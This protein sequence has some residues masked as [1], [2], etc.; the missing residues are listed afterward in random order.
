MDLYTRY[1]F[2]FT[3]C[4]PTHETDLLFVFD[5]LALGSVRS[6]AISQFIEK[7]LS[8]INL[9][10]DR[11]RVGREIEN[12]PTGNIPLGSALQSTDLDEVR[13]HTFTDML[14]RVY[15][16]KLSSENGG[17]ANATKMVVLFVD[18]SQKMNYD[19]FLAARALKESVDYFYVVAVGDNMYTTRFA[20]LAGEENSIHVANY[21]E[22]SNVSDTLQNALC[23][24]F[25][26]H[27]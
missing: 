7:S 11:L 1:I 17:R 24:A 2:F 23:V 6:Q 18:T 14:K 9:A 21:E 3:V 16:V 20:G 8:D 10:T 19:T 13:F 12:C 27:S 15:R 22:L 5:S 26:G 4:H 25:S